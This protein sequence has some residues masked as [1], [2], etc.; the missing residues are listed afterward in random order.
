[1]PCGLSARTFVHHPLYS[2]IGKSPPPR[3]IGKINPLRGRARERETSL[4]L[5]VSLA[6]AK[7]T[8]GVEEGRGEG[9][10]GLEVIHNYQSQPHGPSSFAFESS[11]GERGA[12]PRRVDPRFW[13][14][15]YREVVKPT[16]SLSPSQELQANLR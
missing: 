8:R 9:G 7:A 1:M 4:A 5:G 13:R 3:A 6:Y 16:C 12:I 14:V 10:S 15:G 2:S 11:F